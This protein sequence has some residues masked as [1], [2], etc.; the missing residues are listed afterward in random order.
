VAGY[1]RV[2]CNIK[3]KTANSIKNILRRLEGLKYIFLELSIINKLIGRLGY[4]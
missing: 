2:G 4:I 3:Q 1:D